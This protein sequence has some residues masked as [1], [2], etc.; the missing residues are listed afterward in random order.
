M[1]EMNEY[2]TLE[3]GIDYFIIDEIEENGNTY[4]YLTNENDV[5]DFCIR[6]MADNNKVVALDNEEEFKKALLYFTKKHKE[7]LNTENE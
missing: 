4:L 1:E 5:E 3:D 2:I 6:K 7:E